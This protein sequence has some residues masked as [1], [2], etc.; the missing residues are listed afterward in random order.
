MVTDKAEDGRKE[1]WV[2]MIEHVEWHDKEFGLQYLS[3]RKKSLA[4]MMY[5]NSSG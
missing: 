2:Q 5:V 1:I 4:D 3:S